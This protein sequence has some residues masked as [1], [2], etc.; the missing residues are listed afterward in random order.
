M[1]G[2]LAVARTQGLNVSDA[3]RLATAAGALNVTRRGRGTGAAM[4]VD[5]FRDHVEVRKVD[6]ADLDLEAKRSAQQ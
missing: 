3:L 5:V 4:D 2:G 6:P 1:T